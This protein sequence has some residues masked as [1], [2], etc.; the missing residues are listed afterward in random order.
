[1]DIQNEEITIENLPD[2][3]V[4]RGSTRKFVFTKV[5]DA[6]EAAMFEVNTGESI[7]YEVFRKKTTPICLDF[8]LHVYSETKFKYKYPNDNAFGKWAW[9][10]KSK[11]RAME[12]CDRLVNEAAIKAAQDL[13]FINSIIA[14]A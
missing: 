3:F 12:M 5:K 10:V 6:D 9:T 1:M 13:G 7:H 11:K 4:G 8:A 2:E 14:K